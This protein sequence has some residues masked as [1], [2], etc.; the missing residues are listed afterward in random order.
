MYGELDINSIRIWLDT[1]YEKMISGHYLCRNGKNIENNV[2]SGR[3]IPF[4]KNDIWD[5][6]SS[7]LNGLRCE[8][9][10]R[11]SYI[12]FQEFK[13][14]QLKKKMKKENVIKIINHMNAEDKR[15]FKQYE[16]IL[17]EEAFTSEL[18]AYC[19]GYV[20]CIQLLAGLGIL[21]QSPDI[22]KI[23]NGMK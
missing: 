22:E 1:I 9:I 12:Q 10:N 21:K 8:K 7:F 20:D 16:E 6:I 2:K 4:M 15:K 19:Q 14:I 3:R 23:I 5:E 17:E 18:R 11:K 13:D